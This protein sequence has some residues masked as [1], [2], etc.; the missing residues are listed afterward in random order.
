M[1][2]AQASYFQAPK[3]AQPTEHAPTSCRRRRHFWV[4]TRSALRVLALAKWGGGWGPPSP[5]RERA[6]VAGDYPFPRGDRVS[7]PVFLFSLSGDEVWKESDRE[8]W[9]ERAVPWVGEGA[10]PSS[11]SPKIPL[12][13]ARGRTTTRSSGSGVHGLW[14]MGGARAQATSLPGWPAAPTLFLR[15]RSPYAR[16]PEPRKKAASI[17]PL[18]LS[19]PISNAY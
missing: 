8:G 15:S 3:P 17:L 5:S 13:T 12:E 6:P 1:C 4:R 9:V 7:G 2:G 14:I 19:Q 10:P 11:H 18:E 16:T